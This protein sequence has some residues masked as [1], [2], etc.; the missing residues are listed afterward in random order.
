MSDRLNQLAQELHLLWQEVGRRIEEA[1]DNNKSPNIGDL[2]DL[3]LLDDAARRAK[4]LANAFQIQDNAKE[5]KINTEIMKK[6]HTAYSE[7]MEGNPQALKIIRKM[8]LIAEAILEGKPEPS[9]KELDSESMCFIATACYG[10]PDCYEVGKLR[11]F[12]DDILLSS[13][14][15]KFFVAVYYRYS[16]QLAK[17]LSHRPKWRRRIKRYLLVPIVSYISARYDNDR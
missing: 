15:G 17:W 3:I 16:Q 7:E 2:G 8:Y 6:A 4:E 14:G 9:D 1:N 13:A 12:R 10:D 11:V 5:Q